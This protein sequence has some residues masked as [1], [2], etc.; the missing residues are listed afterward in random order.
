[1]NIFYPFEYFARW[2]TYDLF[3]I[4]NI[5]LAGSLEFF[6]YDTLKILLLIVVITHFMS[7]LRYYLPIE[8]L[9]D[10]LVSRRFYGLDYFLATIF[11]TVTPFCSCSSIPLFIGFMQA[12]IPLG[13]TFSFLITSPLIN[14]V[15]IGLF[16]GLFG[17][18]IT[19]IYVL[20]GILIGMV[21]GFILGQLKME[22][23][24][25]DF[26]WNIQSPKKG[27]AVDKK[28]PVGQ[29]AKIISQEAF[30][31]IKK[32]A[33]YILI[34]VGVG[35]LI[36][37]YVPGGFFEEYL[38]KAGVWGVPVAVIL[39]VPLYSNASG[40]IPIIQSLIAKGIPIGT[41]LAFMMAIVGLSLPEAMILKKVLKWQLLASFF[42]IV[43]LGIILIG[44]LFNALI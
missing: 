13:V 22:K 31:I 42:G 5:A 19:A 28:L 43:T 17:L 24:V 3:H 21:G 34:G 6:V 29:V 14:E 16:I 33:L 37:G 10:F 25:A 41:G 30:G 12:R 26:V 39:A 15:A 32:I 18:K 40:V 38:Q 27:E 11:G 1:M 8:K 20:A 7:W 44:Y 9:R 4:S 36:H 2:L 23:Y 35:A